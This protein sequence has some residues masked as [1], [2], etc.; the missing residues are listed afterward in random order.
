M[1]RACDAE[2]N[3]LHVNGLA[4]SHRLVRSDGNLKRR[5]FFNIKNVLFEED[6]ERSPL[7]EGFFFENVRKSF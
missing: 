6:K 2:E 4:L 7:P 3:G 1:H 5:L